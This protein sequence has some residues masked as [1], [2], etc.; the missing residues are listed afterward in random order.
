MAS[1]N[2]NP[3]LRAPLLG[4]AESHQNQP[5]KNE[6]VG[7]SASMA[8]V[9]NHSAVLSIKGNESRPFSNP[10]MALARRFAKP[11]IPSVP[12]HRFKVLLKKALKPYFY[13]P[14][15]P[16]VQW[17]PQYELCCLPYDLAAGLNAG[18]VMIPTALRL[19]V[20]VG[21]DAVNGYYTAFFSSLLYLLFGSSHYL[22]VGPDL[23]T[24]FLIGRAAIHS[25][26]MSEIKYYDDHYTETLLSVVVVL[27]FMV[28]L[29]S[30]LFGVFQFGFLDL[31]VS[32]AIL[33]GFMLATA[34]T[35][36]SEQLLRMLGLPCRGDDCS[37]TN[38]VW[39]NWKYVVQNVRRADVSTMAISAVAVALVLVGRKIRKKC[40]KRQYWIELCFP[41]L[42]LVVV[43]FTVLSQLSDFKTEGVVVLGS[44]T[45]GF[46]APSIPDLTILTGHKVEVSIN[47]LTIVV[48]GFAQSQRAARKYYE[49]Q[50]KPMDP[51]QELC[52]LGFVNLFTS[53][54]GGWCSFGSL[55]RSSSCNMVG[56]KSNLAHLFTAIVMGL[57]I[58][59]VL[60]F[61]RYTPLCVLS[62][63]NSIIAVGLV[64]V[65]DWKFL[66][67]VNAWGD[68]IL[69][70]GICLITL[71]FGVNGGLMTT[72]LASLLIAGK[73]ITLPS[74][75]VLARQEGE[76]AF[77]DI[78][79]L[80]TMAQ[81]E[82]V[83]VF[84][85]GASLYF[86]NAEAL[87]QAIRSV[88]RWGHYD[89]VQAFLF[90]QA[91]GSQR[92]NV[93][94]TT[95]GFSI[96]HSVSSASNTIGGIFLNHYI[97]DLE[98]LSF[99]D[100]AALSTLHEVVWRYTYVSNKH[101]ANKEKTAVQDKA[102]TR[103]ESSPAVA[104][105]SSHLL[106]DSKRRHRKTLYKTIRFVNV[107][108][109]VMELFRLAGIVKILGED[110]FHRSLQSA[111][112]AIQQQQSSFS[113]FRNNQDTTSS[114]QSTENAQVPRQLHSG[115][116]CTPGGTPVLRGVICVPQGSGGL[117][118]TE[119]GRLLRVAT[120]N[121][122]QVMGGVE[123]I[124]I[125]DEA[126]EILH[127]N[128]VDDMK[129]PK[130]EVG[131]ELEDDW[132]WLAKAKVECAMGAT[133]QAAV[134]EG[135]SITIHK[136][137]AEVGNLI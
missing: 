24:S 111:I 69:A 14:M 130:Y 10:L 87:K 35:I 66:Y 96:N 103:T 57:S 61:F 21:I 79:Q 107:R 29:Y 59:Y 122:D 74:I 9:S 121:W 11:P 93:T 102:G 113:H 135:S 28:G 73:R 72:F 80:N 126:D 91:K 133:E 36:V 81:I 123:A 106:E 120:M 33:A 100:S 32:R 52:A 44:M 65:R 95:R 50:T 19:A 54:F 46:T 71:I 94:D 99:I 4:P 56:Q 64:D 63:I 132:N 86:T 75:A 55:D 2:P 128:Y 58:V 30:L 136:T 27:T 125:E 89:A 37:Q 16:I 53:L 76:E 115:T 12:E 104:A 41:D 127:Q 68:I 77:R 6:S 39:G 20:L 8:T 38:S 43:L 7:R 134:A 5:N 90:D 83:V 13:C 60:P 112:G 70:G 109:Q 105:K 116:P 17:L 101:K 108:P 85:L 82:G 97:F 67:K 42:V 23:I 49:K 25:T 47:A 1:T 45:S 129:A 22:S 118:H 26:V 88:E 34:I 31:L 131:P 98:R 3:L 15:M 51:N 48:L 62:A 137:D 84:E 114:R 40:K 92:S 117:H 119:S 78:T 110:N 124:E 18:L